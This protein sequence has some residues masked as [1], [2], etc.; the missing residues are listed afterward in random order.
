LAD[1]NQ[2][3]LVMA[4]AALDRLLH[5]EDEDIQ[6]TRRALQEDLKQ[7]QWTVIPRFISPPAAAQG[8]IAVECRRDR[9]DLIELLSKINDENTFFEAQTERDI[10]KKFGGGCHQKI[11]VSSRR[12]KH[13]DFLFSSGEHEGK[14]FTEF[15]FRSPNRLE[16]KFSPDE[17][18]APKSS[19]YFETKT[20]EQTAHFD[21]FD[22]IEVAKA[23]AWENKD[24]SGIL[25]ASGLETWRKL[26]QR[27][28]WVHGSQESFGEQDSSRPQFDF[29]KKLRWGK[30]THS[31]KKDYVSLSQE[32]FITP[33]DAYELIEKKKFSVDSRVKC[34]FWRSYSLFEKALRDQPEILHH[35][36]CSGL[37]QT[38]DFIQNHLNKK[39]LSK[40]LYVYFDE[41]HWRKNVGTQ[42]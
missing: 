27:G 1:P 20:L 23:Q 6:E 5:S 2:D 7:L 26:A 28:F 38:A 32:H 19:D 41:N 13:G 34:F 8:A 10:L 21:S 16:K 15:Q 3:G 17:I 18:M 30:L 40:N 9:T 36:H 31:K 12:L 35:V 25:W 33:I 14:S 37:G 4:K 24:F 42:L 29:Y 39:G 22:A 11:G